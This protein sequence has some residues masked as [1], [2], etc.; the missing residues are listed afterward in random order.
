MIKVC[1][2]KVGGAGDDNRPRIIAFANV[3]SPAK[4]CA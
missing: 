3:F 1:S 4:F 2:L